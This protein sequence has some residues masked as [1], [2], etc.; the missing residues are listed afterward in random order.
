MADAVIVTYKNPHDLRLCRDSLAGQCEEIFVRD[1]SDD[2]VLYTQAIN[3]GLLWALGRENEYVLI[4]CDDVIVGP[5]AVRAMSDFLDANPECGIAMPVQVGK[6]GEVTCGGC[7]EAFPYGRHVNSPLTHE[8]YREPFESFWANGACF[9]L[10]LDAVR[11]CGLLDKNMR[12][13]CSDSDYSFTLRARGWRIFVVPEAKVEH[14]PRGALASTNKMLEQQKD[15]DAKYFIRKWVTSLLYQEL[16]F[17]GPK[18]TAEAVN[19][20]LHILNWRLTHGYTEDSGG[21]NETTSK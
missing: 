13:I 6:D 17:E 15:H 2:N 7:T 4:A 3:E 12:F 18:L 1:N 21:I 8:L 14:E 10:R 16:S 19:Q 20:Q 11:E 5:G 9:L